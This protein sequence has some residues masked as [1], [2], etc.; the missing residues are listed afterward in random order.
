[1]PGDS[2][3]AVNNLFDPVQTK[4]PVPW[5]TC[6]YFIPLSQS[7]LFMGGALSSIV[8]S[9]S[10]SWEGDAWGGGDGRGNEGEGLQ[11]PFSEYSIAVRY[12]LLFCCM[13]GALFIHIWTLFASLI[14]RTLFQVQHLDS[15]ELV[16]LSICNGTV[17]WPPSPQKDSSL[18]TLFAIT[19]LNGTVL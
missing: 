9:A 8:S 5:I 16:S 11:R 18:S 2:L 3:W 6:P 7:T 17:I 4:R 13:S 1:M 14:T 15:N 19:V 12:S 10:S